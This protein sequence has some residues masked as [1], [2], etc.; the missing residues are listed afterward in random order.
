M[1]NISENI[2][3]ENHDIEECPFKPHPNYE[4]AFQSNNYYNSQRATILVQA[5]SSLREEK[6]GGDSPV[7]GS[8]D[9]ESN[10]HFS[11]IHTQLQSSSTESMTFPLKNRSMTARKNKDTTFF[12]DEAKEGN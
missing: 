2:L 10:W 4:K 7:M 11:G 5:K 9:K 8:K 6:V 1:E 12:E 3:R